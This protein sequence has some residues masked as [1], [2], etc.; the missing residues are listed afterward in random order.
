MVA[1]SLAESKP[2]I[3]LQLEADNEKG[4]LSAAL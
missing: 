2:N 1:A 3:M 4:G